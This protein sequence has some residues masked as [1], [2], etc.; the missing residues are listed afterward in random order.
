[1]PRGRPPTLDILTPRE[2]EV[3]ALLRQ[4]LSNTGIATQLG[5]SE[6]G[7][8]YHVFMILKRLRVHSRQE[9]ALWN[10]TSH[11]VGRA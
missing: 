11:E 7:A 10:E 4:G 8:K 9:A 6:N 2:W 1:M 3:L 5:I